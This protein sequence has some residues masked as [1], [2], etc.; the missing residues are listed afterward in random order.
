MGSG[1]N[2]GA[3]VSFLLIML[4]RLA[5][6]LWFEVFER[7][8]SDALIHVHAAHRSFRLVRRPL[9]LFREFHFHPCA[10]SEV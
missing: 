8:P 7:L 6:E 2:G 10:C 1:Y 4:E 9:R 3:A 5:N